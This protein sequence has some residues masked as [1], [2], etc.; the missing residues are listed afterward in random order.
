MKPHSRYVPDLEP[1]QRG[2]ALAFPD[3]LYL[4][5]IRSGVLDV[6]DTDSSED[7]KQ[8]QEDM[9]ALEYMDQSDCNSSTESLKP[10]DDPGLA[11]YESCGTE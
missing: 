4:D 6:H 5:G 9:S 1:F 10:S 7:S 2:D 11:P 3:S 8:T